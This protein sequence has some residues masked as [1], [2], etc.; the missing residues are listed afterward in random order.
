[1]PAPMYRAAITLSDAS[2]GQRHG[3]IIA[4]A[5]SCRNAK[6]HNLINTMRRLLPERRRRY[7]QR[8]K[9]PRCRQFALRCAE[10]KS[11]AD[12]QAP[13][14]ADDGAGVIALASRRLPLP[15]RS[16]GGSRS[17]FSVDWHQACVLHARQSADHLQL[18]PRQMPLG[19]CKTVLR[20]LPSR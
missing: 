11:A 13:P 18:F 19:S 15:D 8:S 1:M 20:C 9:V 17:S 2:A 16:T 14:A 12:Q 7:L 6:W 3:Q 4:A 10:P 5:G